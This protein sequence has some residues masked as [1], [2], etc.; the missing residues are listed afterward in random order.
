MFW[1]IAF[2]P[3]PEKE[4]TYGADAFLTTS[5]FNI[6]AVAFLKKKNSSSS[7]CVNK[8]NLFEYKLKKMI[9]N[10]LVDCM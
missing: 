2:G 10:Y 9:Y 5:L 7:V 1:C 3:L 6:R 4:A 8:L